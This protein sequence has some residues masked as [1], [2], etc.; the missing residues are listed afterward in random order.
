MGVFNKTIIPLVLVGQ[1][2]MII[3][4]LSTI[5]YPTPTR[6]I[7]VKYQTN[8]PRSNLVCRVVYTQSETGRQTT[9]SY[10]MILRIAL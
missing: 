5:L 10:V 9:V 8:N 2:D 6:G 3:A 1:Y 7:I 4:K